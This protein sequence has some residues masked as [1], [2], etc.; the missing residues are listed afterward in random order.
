MR[1]FMSVMRRFAPVSAL[2]AVA[3]LLFAVTAFTNDDPVNVHGAA[4]P[5]QIEW[6]MVIHGGAG[7]ITEL[8]MSDQEEAAYQEAM[9]AALRAGHDALADGGSSVDAVEAAINVMEDSPLFNSGKGAVFTA[10]GTNELDS[11]IMDGATLQ[12][13]AVA[14]V[15]HIRNPISLARLVMEESRHVMMAQE[16]AEEFALEQGM[17]LVPSTYFYTEDS[18]RSFRRVQERM[19]GEE[20][21]LAPGG[22]PSAAAGEGPGGVTAETVGGVAD[23]WRGYS[24]P[25]DFHFGTVGAVALDREGNLAAGTSTGGMTYKRWGRIGDSPV[26]GAGTYANN[27][28]CAISATGHGEY[29]IRNVVAHDICARV[30]YQGVSL[31]E[32]ANTVIMESL[33]EKGGSGGVIAMDPEGHIAWPFNTP[34]MFRGYINQDGEITIE[35]Y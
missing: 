8:N 20:V 21:S 1:N 7:S 26:I 30:R 24:E 10:S 18:W 4:P 6:G 28:S 35:F 34:G 9:S 12:A 33:V 3:A 11:S 23:E 15:K 29:F 16:G 22:G 31:E 32:A 5:E 17:E 2:I 13:G 14:G 25:L 27:E 19:R